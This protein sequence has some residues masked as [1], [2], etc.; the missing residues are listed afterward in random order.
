MGR[1][2]RASG[3]AIETEEDL[4]RR[5]LQAL[6]PEFHPELLPPSAFLPVIPY[7][8]L[9]GFS[10]AVWWA[11][12]NGRNSSR[13]HLF[14]NDYTPGVNTVVSDF[15]EATAGGLAAIPLPMPTNKGIDGFGK[16]VWVFPS[17]AWTT[18]GPGLPA[19]VWGY[20]V[21]YFSPL[22]NQTRLLWAQRL[23][24]PWGS[25]MAGQTL[26]FVPSCG[27]NQCG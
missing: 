10:E 26:N 2:R 8:G 13:I 3:S 4:Q 22:S 12:G 9:N 16:D 14:G 11:V 27:F 19:V 25:W 5:R 18:T 23:V 24:S 7:D 20:W 6:L 15:Q 17:A 1:R 21:D